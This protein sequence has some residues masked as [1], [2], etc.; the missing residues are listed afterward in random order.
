MLIILPPHIIRDLWLIAPRRS[1]SFEK[2]AARSFEK[3]Q[4]FAKN[5]VL[6]LFLVHL[7]ECISLNDLELQ[8]EDDIEA[9]KG[10]KDFNNSIFMV[11]LL[12]C[13]Y[14]RPLLP[15][16]YLE[17]LSCMVKWLIDFKIMVQW[18]LDSWINSTVHLCPFTHQYLGLSMTALWAYGTCCFAA[19]NSL[20]L[21]S[22]DLVKIGTMRC[23][24]CHI[25]FHK[26]LAITL[27]AT[28]CV[29]ARV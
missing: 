5:I 24:I 15:I 12:K 14:Y 13:T 8:L 27:H 3:V 19:I 18:T 21:L 20:V 9:R 10:T 11:Y 22:P 23:I 17:I 26:R 4:K 2:M 25:L 28:N 1:R 29:W 6:L 16:V 7:V